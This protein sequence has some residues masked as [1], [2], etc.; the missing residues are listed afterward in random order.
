M[1]EQRGTRLGGHHATTVALQQVLAQ[2]LFQQLHLP[3]ERWLGKVQCGGRAT[4]TAHFGN[5]GEI[6]ETCEVHGR[7]CR[8][9]IARMAVVDSPASA[10]LKAHPK[11]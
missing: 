7:L 1:S 9:S 6:L 8:I 10:A 3:T 2:L 5:C 4:E 11:T